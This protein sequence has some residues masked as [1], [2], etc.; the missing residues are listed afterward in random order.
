VPN[1]IILLEGIGIANVFCKSI[2][3][4]LGCICRLPFVNITGLLLFVNICELSIILNLKG[5][6]NTLSQFELLVLPGETL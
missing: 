6:E 5:R 3:N 4:L 1:P 2:G